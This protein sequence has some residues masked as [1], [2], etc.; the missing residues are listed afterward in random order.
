MKKLFLILAVMIAGMQLQAQ[1][2]F[3]DPNAETRNVKGFHAIKVSDAIDLF[4][5]QSDEEV[6]AVSASETKYRDRIRTTV[7]NGILRIWFEHEGW[8]WW[9]NSGNRKMKAYVSFRT[10]DKLTASGASDVRVTG[11]IKSDNLDLQ[12]GGASDFKGAIDIN[13][14]SIDQ[15]GAS[16]AEIT[17][18]AVTVKAEA[19]GA[20]DLKG[21]NLETENC[22]AHASGA[23]DIQITVNK[24]LNAHASGASSI[25]YKGSAVIKEL[26]SSGASSVSK[27]S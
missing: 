1:K 26:H 19:S 23:S 18:K 27:R 21:Y 17:G 15:S 2:Q 7:E 24:E 5:S 9:K 6:V 10:L 3:N 11:L 25:Y 22:S 14:L 4:L 12:L 8:S 13:T 16:D 20:S